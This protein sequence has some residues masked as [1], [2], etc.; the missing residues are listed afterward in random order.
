MSA[1]A[2]L[3]Y[4]LVGNAVLLDVRV[5]VRRIVT[6]EKTSRRHKERTLGSDPDVESG[7]KR[8]DNANATIAYFRK[9]TSNRVECI[10][11]EV[12]PSHHW[13][14]YSDK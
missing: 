6:F 11:K 10:G 12:S 7:F 14:N 5:R 3:L 1:S 4:L 8:T 13:P 9:R 2:D